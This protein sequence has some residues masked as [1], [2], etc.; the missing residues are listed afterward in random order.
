MVIEDPGFD[1]DELEV[2]VFTTLS[3]ANV[4]IVSCLRNP[5]AIG[6][7]FVYFLNLAE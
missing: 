3:W 7:M 1:E 5:L 6:R 2:R 4:S